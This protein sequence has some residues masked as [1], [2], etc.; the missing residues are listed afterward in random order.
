MKPEEIKSFVLAPD[1]KMFMEI[2]QNTEKFL[3]HLENPDKDVPWSVTLP[4][5]GSDLFFDDPKIS[6]PK[7]WDVD[8]C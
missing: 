7:F 3:K 2:R 5:H 1:H 6:F 4:L 8:S